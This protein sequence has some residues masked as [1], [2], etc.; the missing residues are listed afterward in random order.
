MRAWCVGV[1]SMKALA[2]L[3]LAGAAQAQPYVY[4]VEVGDWPNG[5]AS[6]HCY[7]NFEEARA[8]VEVTKAPARLLPL[9]LPLS[10]QEINRLW[11]L[12]KAVSTPGTS[13]LETFAALVRGAR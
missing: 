13:Q 3:L 1:G 2:A 9:Q 4:V 5:T 12:S 8:L 6:L 10:R 7:Y 11:V